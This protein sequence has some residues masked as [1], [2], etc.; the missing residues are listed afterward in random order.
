MRKWLAIAVI[1]A[2]TGAAQAAIMY[3]NIN[4]TGSRYNPGNGTLGTPRVAFDDVMIP[5]ARLTNP[6]D[7]A[8][9][10]T[11]ITYGIRRAGTAPEVTLNL[12]YSTAT[13]GT[14]LPDTE[15]DVPITQF[16]SVTLPARV[17]QPGFVTE[18]VTVG[19]GV[20]PLFTVA[21]NNTLVAGFN[22]FFAGL[23]FSNA[24]ANN[25]WRVTNGPDGNI[26]SFWVYDTDGP[27]SDPPT[28]LTRR[29]V[30][31]GDNP[32]PGTMYLVVEGNTVPEPASLALLA[33]GGLAL[34]RRR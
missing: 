16:G 20:T 19:D 6:G 14:V 25:G 11:R 22:G 24:D 2:L 18:L 12:Y 9:E 31:G 28:A 34:L 8:L 13:T 17:G 23:S 10:V 29:F 21:L 27:F 15:L 1:T 32:P 26:N 33:L 4:E 7:N 5:D 30:F 3:Q